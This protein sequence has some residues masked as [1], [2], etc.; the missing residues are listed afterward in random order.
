MALLQTQ[1]SLTLP[2]S[3]PS[4][5]APRTVSSTAKTQDLGLKPANPSRPQVRAN[6]IHPSPPDTAVVATGATSQLAASAQSGSGDR[7][8]SPCRA[9]QPRSGG[10][11]HPAASCGLF[12]ACGGQ[13][14]SNAAG[15]NGLV[16]APAISGARLIVSNGGPQFGL[17]G[18]RAVIGR[19]LG[20]ADVVD[21]DLSGLRGRGADRVSRRHAEIIR[22]GMDYF[23]RDLGSLNGTYI[24]G[25]AGLD[26]TN[27]TS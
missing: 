7:R 9:D 8:A 14:R 21:V 2:S 10:G 12:Q 1:R 3:T 5:P 25:R 20:P 4:A 26:A 22:H 23:I 27:S 24:A 17:P 16:H 19:A 13:R 11:D 15:D 6:A 18:S